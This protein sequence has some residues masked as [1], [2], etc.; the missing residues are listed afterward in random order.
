MQCKT[1]DCVQNPAYQGRILVDTAEN[2]LPACARAVEPDRGGSAVEVSMGGRGVSMVLLTNTSHIASDVLA[3][4]KA[5][6]DDGLGHLIVHA[7]V[8]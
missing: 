4:P 6:V 8:V 3:N 2:P 1:S 5:C 7:R